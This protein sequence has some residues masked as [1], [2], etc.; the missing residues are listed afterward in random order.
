MDGLSKLWHNLFNLRKFAMTKRSYTQKKEQMKCISCNS[1]FDFLYTVGGKK[2]ICSKQC[3][4]TRRSKLQKD[5]VQSKP[6]CCVDGCDRNVSRVSSMMCETHYYRKRRTGQTSDPL[7][8]HWHV[9]TGGYLTRKI[10]GHPV[11]SATGI[12][13]QHRFVLFEKIG[14]GIHS[15]HWCKCEIEWKA[16]GKR[17]LVVDHLDGVKSNNA[18]ENLVQSCHNC[19]ANRGLFEN[20]VRKH[21]D[22]PFLHKIF[23]NAKSKFINL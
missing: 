16:T 1:L 3:K 17:K 5:R 18:I 11:A 7:Y 15:C 22:D 14:F 10:I 13:Y 19:N 12:V 6:I 8:K 4:S 23:A 20:W 21:I 2:M 9:G